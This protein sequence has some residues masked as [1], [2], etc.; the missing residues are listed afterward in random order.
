MVVVP[1]CTTDSIVPPVEDT[2]EK[3]F[4][5]LA[6]CNVNL[7]ARVDVLMPKEAPIMPVPLILK[8]P[9]CWVPV[10]THCKLTNPMVLVDAHTG[11]PVPPDCKN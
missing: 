3:G 11:V 1:L 4:S 5:V 7:A 2:T 8:W 10:E 9:V 6:P